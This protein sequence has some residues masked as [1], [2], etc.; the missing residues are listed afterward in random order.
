MN[1]FSQFKNFSFSDESATLGKLIVFG[2]LYVNY[3]Q[4]LIV[5]VVHLLFLVIVSIIIFKTENEVVLV[6]KKAWEQSLNESLRVKVIMIMICR[7]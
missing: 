1:T 5:G 4:I 3:K 2:K 6:V 7:F